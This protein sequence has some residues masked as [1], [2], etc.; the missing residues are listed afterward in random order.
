MKEKY[1]WLKAFAGMNRFCGGLTVLAAVFTSLMSLA[2]DPRL[3]LMAAIGGAF[4]AVGF[5][6]FAEFIE[7]TISARHDLGDIQ[8]YLSTTSKSQPDPDQATGNILTQE[9]GEKTE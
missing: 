3:F 6:A 2:G 1:P 7:M 5:F 8:F 4:S 9:A